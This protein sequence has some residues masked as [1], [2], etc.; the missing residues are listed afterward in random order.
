MGNSIGTLSAADQMEI[1]ELPAQYNLAEDS[2]AVE[3][4]VSLF[5]SDGSFTNRAGQ[6]WA[7]FAALACFARE[8]RQRPEFR[9]YLHWVDN[10]IVAAIDGGARSHCYLLLVEKVPDGHRIRGM[11]ALTD[12]LRRERGRWKIRSRRVL[13]GPGH[14]ASSNS[15]SNGALVKGASVA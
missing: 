10:V 13:P 9:Q 3:A 4:W 1:H 7:G 8:R 11:A 6:S 5:T 2:G 12:E 14:R 15:S